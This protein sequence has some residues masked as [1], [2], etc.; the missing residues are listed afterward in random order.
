MYKGVKKGLLLGLTCL[1][2][3]G[4]GLTTTVR[5]ESTTATTQASVTILPPSNISN[6]KEDVFDAILSL[7]FGG[8]LW[9]DYDGQVIFSVAVAHA[10]LESQ[11]GTSTLL[12]T[13]NNLYGLKGTYKGVDGES[14]AEFINQHNLPELDVTQAD[15]RYRVYEDQYT[16]VLDF[17]AYVTSNERG[18]NQLTS[19]KGLVEQTEA[20]ERMFN[21]PK[22][23]SEEL[24][25]VIHDRGLLKYDE[26]ITNR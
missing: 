23:Y 8:I 25:Q 21:K 9:G 3:G 26:M 18:E 4:N 6:S 11:E 17:M 1:L 14:S 5:A 22:G 24:Q 19:N 10:I 20:V 2:I 16:G 13:N 7:V 15:D 12:E